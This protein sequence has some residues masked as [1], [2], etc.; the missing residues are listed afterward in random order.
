MRGVAEEGWAAP[1]ARQQH[2]TTLS[3]GL[4]TGRKNIKEEKST[5]EF[6]VSP[7]L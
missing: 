2:F 7:S 1:W 3:W 4:G 6:L 5:S